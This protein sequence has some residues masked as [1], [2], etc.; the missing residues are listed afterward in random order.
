MAET[1]YVYNNDTS[2][3]LTYDDIESFLEDIIDEDYLEDLSN[4]CWN[5]VDLPIIGTIGMGTLLKQLDRIMEVFDDEVVFEAEEILQANG[6]T[7]EIAPTPVQDKAYCGV[8]VSIA[9][10]DLDEAKQKLETMDFTV[11]F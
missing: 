2:E 9:K 4:D 7:V 5:P 1:Y 10:E 6:I 3:V 11:I 8:C